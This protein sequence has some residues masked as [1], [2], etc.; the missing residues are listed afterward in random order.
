MEVGYQGLDW[1]VDR[2]SRARAGRML[3]ATVHSRMA[4]AMVAR[5]LEASMQVSRQDEC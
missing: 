5:E 1:Q 2:Y 4:G 3:A